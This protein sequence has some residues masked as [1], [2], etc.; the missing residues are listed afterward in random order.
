M[1]PYSLNGSP[2]DVVAGDW[3]VGKG[4]ASIIV[5]HPLLGQLE[6]FDTHVSLVLTVCSEA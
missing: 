3:F 1:H 4:A 2:Y 6:V 5:A